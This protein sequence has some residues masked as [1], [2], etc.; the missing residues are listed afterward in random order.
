MKIGLLQLNPVA[1][2][3]SGNAA[4]IR[5]AAW[6]A[7]EAGAELC[8]TPEMALTGCPPRDLLLMP[9]FVDKAREEL[10]RMAVAL[11]HG[12]ALLVGTVDRLDAQGSKPLVNCAALVVNGVVGAIYPKNLLPP[13]GVFDES[14]YFSPG[15]CPGL[16]TMRGLS[17]GVTIGVDIGDSE[18]LKLGHSG[19]RDPLEALAEEGVH[20]IVNLS[21]SP[22]TL[23]RQEKR[24]RLLA[25]AAEKYGIPLLCCNQVG[26]NDDL[27]FDGR[28]TVVDAK[29]RLAGRAKGFEPDILVVD[30][31]HLRE[32]AGHFQPQIS[33]DDFS[34]EDEAW[35]AL[36]LGLKDYAAKC[37]FT[38]A[39]FGL[40]GGID[41]ALT[42]AIA[43]QALGPRNVLGVLMPSPYSSRAS[44]DDS[45]E[46]ARRLGIKTRTIPI[47]GIMAS[48][49]DALAPA[50]A[51]KAP[52]VTEEN[53]QSRIRGNLL[54]ALSNK[55]GTLLLNTGNKS[56]LAVGYCTI[57]GDMSGG[58]S[59]ISDVPKTLVYRL[60]EYA[61]AKGP[62][63]I[64]RAIIDKA[65]S[66]ELRPDQ[67][68]EDSLP[69]YEELDAI[70]KLRVERHES[71]A[72]IIAAGFDSKMVKRICKLVKN[73][74]FKRRQAAPGLK[75][76]DMAF[77]ADW[78]MPV[79]S[80][81]DV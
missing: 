69:P 16:V 19:P 39:L 29:G 58:L 5:H 6:Q 3:I 20:V 13:H 40:S 68:D 42:A 37:G 73:A 8:V 46:L 57:Y 33:R 63:V 50:F 80:R 77:G 78:R 32:G 48:F 35:R 27:V 1:G 7:A 34:E 62:E 14:R 11:E 60:A 76:T 45:L 31:N 26:G 65:P 9:A 25:G 67:R 12:P 52:D 54:M 81:F 74:E 43:A 59:V 24:E 64:P 79:A 71:I 10:A 53:I 18:D 41:S 55:F 56:E 51:G 22:F 70:L 36:T 38:G 49:T 17:I 66:A 2:D 21:A 44:L 4:L 15:S 72:Q 23:G 30:V 61:N 47:E 28:S 75:I